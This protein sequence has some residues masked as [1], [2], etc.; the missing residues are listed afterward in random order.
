MQKYLLI[1]AAEAALCAV[2]I[3]AVFYLT[4]TEAEAPTAKVMSIES[5][6][7]QRISELSPE[8]EVLGG[9]F[10]VTDIRLTPREGTSV[11]SGTGVVSYE[12][13][14]NAYT[15]DFSYEADDFKGISITNFVIRK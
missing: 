2:A 1:M 5:F 10:Q 6:V 11:A 12:D 13:G 15:A 8:K 14:H 4:G 9:T 7:T 3:F